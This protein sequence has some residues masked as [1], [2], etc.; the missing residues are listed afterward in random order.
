MTDL[1]DQ[2]QTTLSGAYTI[3][4]ELG[5]GGM[6]RVFVAE[7]RA[8]GRKVVVKVLPP[9]LAGA[10]S[11][12]RFKREISLA[13][14]LQHPHI[15]PLHSAGEATGALYFTMPLVEGES[16]RTRLARQGEL[17]VNEAVRLLREIASALAYAHERGI[18]HRD[19]KP[20]NI[21]LSGGSAMITDFGV[22]KALSASSN[23]ESEG[24]T[25]LGV[26][27]G[28]P[29][30]M[31]PEQA[32][33][34]PSIDHRADIYAFGVVAYELLSGQPPFAG[35][36]AQN[37]LAAH[38]TETPEALVR[39]RPGV[40]AALGALVMRCL[41]KR[42]ADRPQTA[43]EVVHALDDLT[44]PSGGTQPTS[45]VPAAA[46][47]SRTGTSAIGRGS[48]LVGAIAVVVV[49]IVATAVAMSKSREDAATASATDVSRRLAVLPFLSLDGDSTNAYLGDGMAT[50]L[51]S[52]L[53][54]PGMSV[55]SRSSAFALR[56]KTAG[57]AGRALRADAVVEGTVKRI[58]DRLRVT[59]SLVNVADDAVL[60]S[61]KF[62]EDLTAIYTVHDSIANAISA[63]YGLGARGVPAAAA[64]PRDPAAHDLV[65]RGWYLMDQYT[66]SS[67]KQAIAVFDRAI[68]L[69]ST[70]ALAWVGLGQAWA[71]ISDDFLPPRE[72]LAQMR[73]AVSRAVA[74]D[75]KSAEANA[76]MGTLLF[77][78]ERKV[79]EANEYFA[80][81]LSIDS[82]NVDAGL[83]YSHSLLV[84]GNRDSAF[85]VLARAMRISP[86]SPAL[87]SKAPWI[88]HMTGHG[89]DIPNLCRR[90][91]ELASAW[92]ENCEAQQLLFSRRYAELAGRYGPRLTD[93]T[94]VPGRTAIAHYLALAGDTAAAKRELARAEQQAARRYLSG[95]TTAR[96]Y[97]AL[98]DTAKALDGLD[99]ELRANGGGIAIMSVD[100]TWASLRGNAR[101]E[102]L[103]RRAGF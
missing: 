68:V 31:A 12:D 47:A 77:W 61:R 11:K 69:D 73:R 95:Y 78:Y 9:E 32:T 16:L 29:A 66:E 8:L 25:S 94:D 2:L 18:V 88:Y 54:V 90:L 87:L 45:A 99:R 20:D 84:F 44:T 15:V 13:A 74:L 81:A 57:E 59:A 89:D 76:L 3:E 26:A 102:S 14:R 53:A 55:V 1:R 43:A 22:A 67:L 6:S 93:A 72:T 83:W 34:D 64:R 35:R 28:T 39:R 52:A 4:R 60:W 86:V 24:M 37:M 36:P 51:T 79:D 38:V 40:P 101:F 50:D 41:E 71:R 91:R 7:E 27:L 85:A 100:S 17:P 10:V 82:S 98:G 49:A 19:I 80:R 48:W 33:A 62:D 65:L 75:P 58:G 23:D 63:V 96:V 97:L 70:Y 103:L 92:A 56:G 5:G 42:A 46:A 30:Y 21:L